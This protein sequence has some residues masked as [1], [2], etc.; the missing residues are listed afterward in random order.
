MLNLVFQAQKALEILNKRGYEAYVVGGTVRNFILGKQAT[1]IDITTSALPRQ[2]ID[3]FKDYKVIETGLKHGTVTVVIDHIHIEITTYRTESGYSDARHPDSVNFTASL[4]K[5]CA[6]RD[7]TM[8]AVCYNPSVGFVDYYGGTEDIK[9]GVIRCVGDPHRRFKEDALRILRAVRFASV[10]GFE[11]EENTKQAI[12][13]CKELLENISAERIYTELLKLLC[14]KN[15]KQ[16]LMDY[17]EVLAVFMPE[18][19]ALKG[20]EQRNH[21]HIYDVLE[22]TA[23]AVENALP[24]PVL[25]LATLMHD[26]GKPATFTID[27][28]GTGHFYGHGDVSFEIAKNILRRLKVSNEEY[29]LISYLV[30]YHD[31]H[32]EPNEKSVRRALN[33]HGRERMKM[34]LQLKRADNKGQNIKDFDRTAEYDNLEK[35][36][37]EILAKEQ[38]FSLKQ[39][40]VNGRDLMDIGVPPS[41]QTGEILNSLLEM[42]I[43]G[44]VE[45]KKE[46]LLEYAEQIK[47]QFH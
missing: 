20:F 36:I 47:A 13:D 10:L 24:Q 7:F 29:S 21:H 42:V 34:L 38:C 26:F 15:V 43:N 1:D 44:D 5:D 11:I 16:V 33:K 9:N 18:I 8:N 40:A 19:M 12:F 32:I 17:T 2:T 6:R 4:K 45:N 31:V 25:R 28:K 27:E 46:I 23:V 35:M 22:H 39:L 14:G 41:K 37:D 30:K 3:V